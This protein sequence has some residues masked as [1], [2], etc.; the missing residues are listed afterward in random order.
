MKSIR[1]LVLLAVVMMLAWSVIGATAFGQALNVLPTPK[2][3]INSSAIDQQLLKGQFAGL[4]GGGNDTLYSVRI[5]SCDQKE[6]S[7]ERI[8]LRKNNS[9]SPIGTFNIS[10]RF[11]ENFEVVLAG[12]NVPF[13]NG[14]S[15]MVLVDAWEDSIGTYAGGDVDT[16]YHLTGLEL[17]IPPNGI[18]MRSNGSFTLNAG[19]TNNNEFDPVN[20]TPLPDSSDLDLLPGDYTRTFD[21]YPPTYDVDITVLDSSCASF[22]NINDQLVIRVDF[23]GVINPE[24]I[25]DSAIFVDLSAFGLSANYQMRN[26]SAHYHNFADFDFDFWQDTVKVV[27]DNMDVI[28]GHVIEF[29]AADMAG[30]EGTVPF[31]FDRPIDTISPQFDSLRFFISENNTGS[32][33]SAAI[34]DRLSVIAYMTSNGFF[35]IDSVATYQYI[36]GTPGAENFRTDTTYWNLDDVTNGNG[37]W[38]LDFYLTDEMS[39]DIAAGA[40]I[41]KYI[42][43][44]AWDNACNVAMDSISLQN[45]LD[46]DPPNFSGVDY[47]TVTN[48]DSSGCTNLGDSI[49]VEADL[50]GSS[51]IATVY[52]N[53][54]DGGLGGATQEAMGLLGAGIWEIRWKIGELMDPS[55]DP[56]PID[57]KDANSLPTDADFTVWTY[58]IDDAGNIDSLPSTALTAVLGGTANLDTR[59]P[60]AVNQDDVSIIILAGGKI[61]LAW[62]VTAQATDAQYFYISVDSTGTGFGA[63]DVFGTTF[64]GEYVNAGPDSNAWTSEVLTHAQNYR[65]VIRTED[66]CGNFEFNSNIFEAI[67]DAQA[68]SACVV[69]PAAGLNFGPNNLLEITATSPDAD[70]NAAWVVWRKLDRGDGTPGA[71]QNYPVPNVNDMDEFGQTFRYTLD[72]GTDPS[73]EGTWQVLILTMDEVGN[74]RSLSEAEADCGFFEFF[75][76]P[77]VPVCDFLTIN[78]AF[79]PQT[80]CGFEVSRTQMNTAEVTIT[81]PDNEP[82]YVVDSWVVFTT[83]GDRTRIDFAD[84]ATLPYSFNFWVGDWPKTIGGPLPTYLITEITDTRNGSFCVDSVKLCLPDEVAPQAMITEPNE[85]QCVQIAQSSLN[86]VEITVEIDPNSYDTSS[87]IRVE[88]FY[89]LDGTIPGVKIGE[90]AIGDLDKK[91]TAPVNPGATIEWDNSG[92]EEGY[93]WLYAIVYDDVNNAYTT[94]FVRVCLDGTMPEMTLT[95]EGASFFAGCDTVPSWK[96]GDNTDGHVTLSANLVNL[97]GIDIADVYFYYQDANADDVIDVFYFW[98]QIGQAMPANNNS[99]WTY[100]WEFDDVLDCGRTYRIRVAVKDQAGN[101]MLDMD[102]D[103]NF[104]DYTFDDAE[105]NGAGFLLTY[106]C[107]APQPAF[108][109][110]ANAGAENMTWQNP[111]EILG[112]SAE[113]FAHLGDDLT[114]EVGTNPSDDSCEVAR[115]DYYLCETFVGTS[116]SMPTNWSVSFN[117]LTAGLVTAEDI[118]DGYYQC[119]LEARAFDNLGQFASDHITVYFLD[120]VP[121]A[122]LILEPGNGEYVCGDVSLALAAIHDES[123]SKVVWYYWP[124]AG[125]PAVQIDEV[126]DYDEVSNWESVWHTLNAVPDDDYYVGASLIDDAGNVTDMELTKVLVHVRNAI[127][128]VTITTPTGGFFCSNEQFCATVNPNGAAPIDFVQFQWKNATD[129]NGEWQNFENGPDQ[130]APWCANFVDSD[131]FDYADEGFY[132]FRALVQSECGQASYSEIVTLFYDSTDPDVRPVSV[133]D[134]IT[135]FD[136]DN[137]NDPTPT[138]PVGTQM[139]TWTFR[140]K[141]DQSPFGPSPIY[142]SGLGS[143]CAQNVCTDIVA[144]ENGYFTASWDMSGFEAG[145]YAWGVVVTDAVGC[146]ETNIDIIFEITAGEPTLALV[147]GC[148]RG[149]LFGIAEYGAN[150]MFQQRRNGGEWVSIGGSSAQDDNWL[151]NDDWSYT[152]QMWG[153][154]STPWSPANGTYEVRLL[155]ENS[156]GYDEE[157]SPIT[158]IVVTDGACAVTGAPADF[159][160]GTIER[161]LENDCDNLEGLATI[162][163][164]YGM[165]WGLSVA[166]NVA[167]E[168]YSFDIIAF[169]ALNQQGGIDRY[170]GSFDF[171]ALVDDGF[172]EGHVFFVD[173]DGLTAWSINNDYSTFWVSR[174]FGTGGPVT[175]EDVTVDIPAEWSDYDG[176]DASALAIWKSKIARASVWQDWLLT[177]VGDNN[178]MMTYLTDPSCSN[179]CGDDG[180]YAVVTMQYN[181]QVTVAPESLMVAWWDGE[182]NWR[183]DNVYFPSTVRG[184]YREGGQ[185]WVQFAVTCFGDVGGNGATDAW[186]SVVKR[187]QYDGTTAIRRLELY[188]SCGDYTGGYPEFT[189][190]AVE[191]FQS[192]IDWGTLEVYLDGIRIEDR[193]GYNPPDSQSTIKQIKGAKTALDDADNVDIWYDEVSAQ[194]FVSFYSGYYDGDNI[195]YS[196]SP[197]ACGAHDLYIRLED[198]QHR[199]QSVRDNLMV[200]CT[201]PDVDFDNAYVSKNPTLTFT[202]DDAESGVDWEHVFVDIFFVTKGD[203]TAGGPDGGEPKEKVAFIQ[204]FFPDQIKDY[205]QEDGRTVIIPT[206]YDLDDERGVIGVIY[207]GYYDDPSDGFGGEFGWIGDILCGF[208]LCDTGDPSEWDNFDH[209]YYHGGGASDCAGNYA[210]PHVQYF[211]VDYDGANIIMTSNTNACPLTFD[212]EDDGAGV[213]SIEIRE[214]NVLLDDAESSAGAVDESGE[215][216]FAESGNGGTL[217]YC[218]SLGVTFEI[219][220]TDELGGTS[221]FTSTNQGNLGEGSVSAWVGPNPYDPESDEAFSI[222]VGLAQAANVVVQIYDYAGGL[223][224]TLNAGAVGAGETRIPWD[225]RTDGGTMV[226]TGAYMARIEASGTSGSAASAVVWIAVV[227]K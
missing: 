26:D 164:E 35:E 215:W 207:D 135:T 144:D 134:G 99:I 160:P 98:N 67:P 127:P 168:D 92:L 196:Y 227:E 209:Y 218:P 51:D 2:D 198:T 152:P 214:N 25:L 128:T 80:A 53:F 36:T 86:G 83:S 178:G 167:T 29:T 184:F 153:V 23:D 37:I 45:V 50:S 52:S 46:I 113:V 177:P 15:L 126:F 32:D 89:S 223:V 141:D 44:T 115:V 4:A 191:P 190:Q 41:N 21:L 195:Y 96:V 166:Y 14:D 90:S 78:G 219:K 49:R 76:N 39:R 116:S 66:D 122:A 114:F 206:H 200:D 82:V 73:T 137:A 43:L 133:T 154:Y 139:L 121:P 138:F 72:L 10:G 150:T 212:V 74:I 118:A 203:T 151:L 192:T 130:E 107:T 68:P 12:I 182:G 17:V 159:G 124:A 131:F 42:W 132:H 226:G 194:I 222:N 183:N 119:D 213:A 7:I 34:G 161:N 18:E 102:G 157:L 148:W 61:R 109:L 65:F 106:D 8:T 181:N 48:A 143:I 30:N 179:L 205:L 211:T 111:S 40:D 58:A 100:D 13:A 217:Y 81:D 185:N 155:S 125:G 174:D 136:I 149:S 1:N 163:S 77:N 3:T 216:Y 156:T 24:E 62:P 59:R 108:T 208:G 22:I 38:R 129:D 146:N 104:D 147:A 199:P 112:G 55:F 27:E 105:A 197:L 180:Q 33:T 173:Y 69:F 188:P 189:Y 87:P 220:V 79:A 145:E 54:L 117:P 64:N 170:A 202:I 193:D 28:A 169:T 71:W 210:D 94:P 162:N 103:G 123:L 5:K 84:D 187:T 75:W 172:G 60:T 165:P 88:F 47:Q 171:D 6:F 20:C 56:A 31:Q 63:Y 221:T 11:D 175:F 57:A 16:T 186:Y 201:E 9:T 176:T 204:T 19:Y 70:I 142:N 101:W 85:Y 93:V 110:F 97:T 140:A 91:T 224:K 225:G 95:M 158:T 120:D